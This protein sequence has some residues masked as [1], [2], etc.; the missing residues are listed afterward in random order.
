[1]SSSF[2]TEF[3][4]PTDWHVPYKGGQG[5]ICYC[6]CTPVWGPRPG[7]CQRCQQ[8]PGVDREEAA[9]WQHCSEREEVQHSPADTTKTSWLCLEMLLASKSLLPPYLFFKFLA[10]L[11]KH[12]WGGRGS[13]IEETRTEKARIWRPVTLLDSAVQVKSSCVVYNVIES[14]SEL[15]YVP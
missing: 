8:G 5:G 2:H 7:L 11:S 4:R 3:P 15:Q 1:M 10:P 9:E 12:I 6:L 13:Q 14:V